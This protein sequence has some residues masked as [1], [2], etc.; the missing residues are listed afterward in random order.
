MSGKTKLSDDL[1]DLVSGGLMQLDG[2]MLVSA[3]LDDGKVILI[4]E[5][6][7][8]F[9]YTAMDSTF[10]SVSPDVKGALKDATARMLQNQIDS[11]G[12]V[13]TLTSDCYKKL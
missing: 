9:H 8:K 5:K 11:S 7:S 2:E 3:E 6:G 4:G 13:A 10:D 12:P 1:M